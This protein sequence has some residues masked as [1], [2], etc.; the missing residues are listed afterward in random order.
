MQN[1]KK[2]FRHSELKELIITIL[3]YFFIYQNGDIFTTKL[4]GSPKLC[5]IK[6]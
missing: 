6:G 1:L 4:S 5:P 3:E 2:K